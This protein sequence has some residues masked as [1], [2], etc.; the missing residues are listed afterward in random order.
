MFNAFTN[1]IDDPDV[2][3]EEITSQLKDKK[4]LK[5]TIGIIGC[6]F[7]FVENGTINALCDALPFELI[8]CAVQGSAVNSSGGME[9][10]SLTVLTSDDLIFTS[11]ISEPIFSEN[12]EDSIAKV[13]ADAEKSG[14]KPSLIF[15][16][17]P[18]TTDVSG[19]RML[20]KLDQL[21]GGIPIFG[22]LSNDTSLKYESSYVFLNNE[23]HLRKMVLL[24]LHGDINPRFYTTAIATRNIQQQ[25]AVVTESTGYLVTKINNIPLM[26]Y[27]NKIG[28]Q[29]SRLAAVSMLPFLVDFGD[30]TLPAAYS[31]Y[32]ISEEGAY[33]G[34]A[35]PVGSLI[36][37][38]EIDYSSVMETA[39]ITLRAALADI[40]KNGA[41][42]MI[43]IPCFTR[44]LVIIPNTEDEIKKSLEIVGDKVPFTLIYS[45]GELC[46][47]YNKEHEIVNRFHNLTY[48]VMV[49]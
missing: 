20:K 30:G 36:T 24:F 39:E 35:I 17:G 1:E 19:D 48:T 18:I 38:A 16:L 3:V 40:E 27:F 26:E 12:A 45:G 41:N 47:T 28:V 8:G 22:T 11:A 21:S 14:I 9:Q 7:E 15:A 10:L 44:S 13:Y 32:A 29:T 25:N 43:A 2:A 33:C 34:S 4:L 6:H 46:P 31:M 49:F 23:Q 5:N 42:G 37:F